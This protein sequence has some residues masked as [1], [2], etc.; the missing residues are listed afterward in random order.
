MERQRTLDS[1]QITF[2]FT[3]IEG[4]TRL[5]DEV[6]AEMALALARH[7]AV[8]RQAIAA[9][10]GIVFKT[11]GDAFCAAFDSAS[12]AVQAI[13][14][15]QYALDTT[16]WETPRP[17]K[18]RMALHTGGA[19]RRDGDFFGPSLNRVARLLSTGHGGQM[20][21]SRATRD[22][23]PDQLLVDYPL[24][25]LGIHRLKDLV[26]P[27]QIFQLDAPG[28]PQIFAP[29]KT[30]DIRLGNL[31]TPTTPIIGRTREVGDTIQLANQ[32]GSALIT[33]LG[34][35]GTGK[36]RLAIEVASAVAG[37]FPDGAWFVDLAPIEDSDAV[38]PTI[39]RTLGVVD[40]GGQHPTDTLCSYLREKRLLL[41]LDN[42]EQVID[43]A[44][45][46]GRLL[47][48]STALQLIVT[49]RTPLQLRG[50]REYLLSPLLLSGEGTSPALQLLIERAQAVRPDFQLTEANAAALAQICRRLDGMP[51]AIELAAARLRT[52]SPERLLQQLERPLAA[53][54]GG[55]RDLPARQQTMTAA[56]A[57]G[58]RLLAPAEQQ[59]LAQ[60]A[61]FS[62]GWST[63]AA[64][65]ICLVDDT[66][67]TD[68]L[69]ARLAMQSMILIEYDPS[70]EIRYRML[71]PIRAYAAEQLSAATNSALLRDR[72]TAYFVEWADAAYFGL[73][74]ADDLEWLALIETEAENLREAL[75]DACITRP[76]LLRSLR[77]TGA[78]WQYWMLRGRFTEGEPWMMHAI[79]SADA[80]DWQAS[81]IDIALLS[82]AARVYF[83]AARGRV[84]GL[85][86]DALTNSQRA[87]LAFRL[88]LRADDLT[89]LARALVTLGRRA[90]GYEEIDQGL[91][92]IATAR[93]AES[94]VFEAQ[95][96]L[97]IDQAFD[98]RER[99][100]HDMAIAL[101]HRI[102]V[103][104]PQVRSTLL[105]MDLFASLGKF[106]V[107]EPGYEQQADAFYADAHR[108]AVDANVGSTAPA[109]LF[110]RMY[111]AIGC[112]RY[113]DADRVN[114]ERQQIE[115]KLG[116]SEGVGNC[117]IYLG[118]SAMVRG[119]RAD[120]E[121]QYAHNLQLVA[122]IEDQDYH[123]WALLNS[124]WCALEFG[125]MP[126]TYNWLHTVDTLIAR[127]SWPGLPASRDE[128][129]YA[130]TVLGLDA[131]VIERPLTPL[132][133]D[134]PW[135]FAAY[136]QARH[137]LCRGELSAARALL[138][139]LIDALP[140]FSLVHLH[141]FDRLRF[142]I[143]AAQVA[144]LSGAPR[145]AAERLVWVIETA[146]R[147]DSR[148]QLVRALDA[149]L[150]LI[151]PR[152]PAAAAQLL[153]ANRA[154]LD[155]LQ[156]SRT[157]FEDQLLQ[158]F[159]MPY[160]APDA[161][162]GVLLPEAAA[163]LARASLQTIGTQ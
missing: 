98:L 49:S 27:E 75:T 163:G 109:F 80:I 52:F 101:A 54:T 91:L 147:V 135:C 42:C 48:E 15:A 97:Q 17:I 142:Q 133:S 64:A 28:R 107:F 122:P 36:T 82:A 14:A 19:E 59:L 13:L 112:G 151:A 1:T 87:E 128:F 155:E 130:T 53:L 38:L 160:C 16:V 102:A 39:S 140:R 57:W 126:A 110:Q 46:I 150:L 121:I 3:D 55:A 67:T 60:L 120:A 139:R 115:Q 9:Y 138:D 73:S 84:L 125:D 71:E 41:V 149:A 132:I 70:G 11:I 5:W 104:V 10:D 137:L 99:G 95:V 143:L 21:L 129:H 8:L 113:D 35:G 144:A 92:A 94:T 20:L 100:E 162:S 152:D 85:H 51:L 106:F 145:L 2:L 44:P 123:A 76:D 50:E 45:A 4:S 32:P 127:R 96:L 117:A 6:P 18:V 83:G 141:L 154:R 72:H 65:A 119:R 158:R 88:A 148:L 159:V 78:L 131:I 58:Y 66:T 31:P 40:Q 68:N 89:L 43:A 63:E 77:L 25:D 47:S 118:Y 157:P 79:R 134:A 7:D 29:L 111:I 114:R 12:E 93:A 37:R 62:G 156:A 146:L 105:R 34:P 30:Q 136:L 23:L 161:S 124:G 103:H 108:L 86:R 24:R 22:L 74:S 33:L 81:D 116:K 26:R 56:I 61:I 69:L 153:A 90:S